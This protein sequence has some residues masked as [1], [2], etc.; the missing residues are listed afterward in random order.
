M[1][2]LF[3]ANHILQS[4]AFISLDIRGGGGAINKPGPESRGQGKISV[5]Y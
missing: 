2:S 4:A 3:F 1:L 5:N